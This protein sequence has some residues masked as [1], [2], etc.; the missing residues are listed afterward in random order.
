MPAPAT[1]QAYLGA[2]FVRSYATEAALTIGNQ[3]FSRY[4]VAH[5]FDCPVTRRAMIILSEALKRLGV[6]TVKDA[7]AINAID[8]ADLPGVGTTTL[9]LFLCW[10]RAQ[11]HNSDAALAAWYGDAVTFTT[12]QR[13]VAKRKEREAPPRRRR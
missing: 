5:D 12:L 13:R 10:Q 1:F 2:T 7:M 6:R 8:L 9:Y 4:E 11:R 3:T